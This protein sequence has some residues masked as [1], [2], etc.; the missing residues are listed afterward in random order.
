MGEPCCDEQHPGDV[1]II[2]SVGDLDALV[3]FIE[4]LLGVGIVLW[5]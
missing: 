2:V 4:I 5:W 3:Q 1:L